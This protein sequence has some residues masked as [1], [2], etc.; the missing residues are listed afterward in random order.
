MNAISVL[1][2][3]GNDAQSSGVNSFDESIHILQISRNPAILIAFDYMTNY[4]RYFENYIEY[5]LSF[6]SLIIFLIRNRLLLAYRIVSCTMKLLR[7]SFIDTL[8]VLNRQTQ[9]TSLGY[10]TC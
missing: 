4:V 3:D 7:C 9:E 10:R 1:I 2:S 8:C 6:T 5:F